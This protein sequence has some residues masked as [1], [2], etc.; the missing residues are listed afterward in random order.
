M[1][2]SLALL[3]AF[4]FLS[5]P[6]G[7]QQGTDAAKSRI[8]SIRAQIEQRPQDATLH[9]YLARFQC[10]AGNVAAA[11]AALEDVARYGDGF[12]PTREGFAKCWNDAAFTQVR[13]RME[14]R[15]PRLDYAPTAF[16][17]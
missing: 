2:F 14:A 1:R 17:L 7:A 12:L 8:D 13:A 16:E 9:F 3:V 6:A 5:S 10:E 15:L 4:A 11:V